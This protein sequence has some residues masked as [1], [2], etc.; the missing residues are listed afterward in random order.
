MTGGVEGRDKDRALGWLQTLPAGGRK[1][2]HYRIEIV[3][4]KTGLARLTALN[5]R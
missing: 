5:G 2:Y 3:A 4:D 1:S